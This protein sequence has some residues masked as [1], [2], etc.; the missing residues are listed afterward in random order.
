MLSR[1]CTLSIQPL[2]YRFLYIAL[3]V[4]V[5]QDCVDAY[6]NSVSNANVGVSA[7]KDRERGR[8]PAK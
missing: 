6:D 1:A 2:N 8:K 7:S 5:G 4:T 3:F